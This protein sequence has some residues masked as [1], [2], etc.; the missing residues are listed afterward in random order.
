MYLIILIFQR[1]PNCDRIP[2]RHHGIMV[3]GEIK[4]Y[5]ILSNNKY[6]WFEKI[7]TNEFTPQINYRELNSL[8]EKYNKDDIVECYCDNGFWL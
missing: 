1:Q 4:D 7:K 8:D 5:E 2:F 3:S 6:D